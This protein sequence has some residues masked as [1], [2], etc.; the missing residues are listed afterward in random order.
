MVAKTPD[1]DDDA[2]CVRLLDGAEVCVRRLTNDDV[3]AV[4]ALHQRLTDREQYLRF[5]VPHPAYLDKFAHAV[6]Q[7]DETRCA[8]GAFDG[9][10]LVGVANYALSSEPGV[11]EIAV[12]VAHEDHLR[13]V[14]TML[15]RQLGEIASGKGIRAFVADVLVEN[16]PMLKVLYAWRHTTEHEGSVLKV[17]VDLPDL[18]D[19]YARE[20]LNAD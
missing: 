5:F 13:G 12:A 6:V 11:A 7:C 9:G 2:Q 15:L 16:S 17:R 10:H 8:V 3:E 18:D 20:T 4:L 14:A 19:P 1:C